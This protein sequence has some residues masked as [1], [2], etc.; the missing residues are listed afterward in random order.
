MVYPKIP[1]TFILSPGIFHWYPQQGGYIFFS[2]KVQLKRS[3]S[4]WDTRY[5]LQQTN[6]L[7]TSYSADYG[8]LVCADDN[9]V[10]STSDVKDKD[11]LKEIIDKVKETVDKN[12]KIVQEVKDKEKGII[13]G[14][15]MDYWSQFID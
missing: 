11:K 3:T 15:L 10:V 7:I 1:T 4:I 9:N 2:G 6:N 5:L 8:V 12:K 14:K 13:T